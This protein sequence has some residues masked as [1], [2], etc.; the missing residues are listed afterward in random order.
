[1]NV[2]KHTR[3]GFGAVALGA[4]ALAIAGCG[5]GGSSSSTSASAPAASTTAS[6]ASSSSASGGLATV[7]SANNPSLDQSIL[8]DDKGMT[9][10]LF[11]KDT[12]MQSQCSGECVQDWPPLTTKGSPSAGS[13]VD[14]S[15]LGTTK[16]SDGTMQV[17][18]AGHPLYYY[19][20]DQSA[21]DTNGEGLDEF[22][23]EWDAVQPSGEN[24]EA[25]GDSSS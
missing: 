15:K 8:V 7:S 1:M 21:G 16:R 22:G 20:G 2:A 12:G 11:Q 9:L 23:A 19:A 24:A 4:L 25:K 6:T 18:Y 5:S 13:G 17:T 14:S 10:Y 3:F